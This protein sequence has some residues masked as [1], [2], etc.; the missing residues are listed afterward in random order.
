MSQEEDV[1]RI[2]GGG[3]CG[4]RGQNTKL[5]AT[6]VP[7]LAHQSGLTAGLVLIRRAYDQRDKAGAKMQSSGL[8]VVPLFETTNQGAG[9][10][11]RMKAY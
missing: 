5:L 8:E 10:R 11:A 7:C 6:K 3:L 1:N 2:C 9:D 4:E